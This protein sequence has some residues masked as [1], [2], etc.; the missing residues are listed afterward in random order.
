MILGESVFQKFGLVMVLARLYDDQC[1]PYTCFNL[2]NKLHG[3]S[4]TEIHRFWTTCIQA[5]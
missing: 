3:L 5:L 4:I 2:N 1:D